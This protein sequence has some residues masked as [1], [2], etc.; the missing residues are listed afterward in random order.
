MSNVLE[1]WQALAKFDDPFVVSP[2]GCR[3]LIVQ[4]HPSSKPKWHISPLQHQSK[5]VAIKS[6]ILSIGYRLKPG[7]TIDE[8]KLLESVQNE[9]FDPSNIQCQINS[10]TN[11]SGAVTEALDCL[12]TNC[13]SVKNTAIMLGVSERTLQRLILKN[14]G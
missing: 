6:G 9:Q 1:V 4:I 10:F 2:D 7:V 13:A 14:T 11:L 12:A 5:T 3:D 8:K